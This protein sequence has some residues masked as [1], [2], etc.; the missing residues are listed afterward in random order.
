VLATPVIRVD[1]RHKSAVVHSTGTTNS[2]T[3]G[4]V[5]RHV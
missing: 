2:T 5:I 4:S 3:L 1:L